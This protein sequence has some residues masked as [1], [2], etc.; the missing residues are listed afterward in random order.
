MTVNLDVKGET[1][2]YV[3]TISFGGFL[4]ELKREL[5]RS[6]DILGLKLI[7]RALLN[8]FNSDNVYIRCTCPDF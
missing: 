5:K 4:D 8:S 6:N 3:V 1:N 2:D 7:I